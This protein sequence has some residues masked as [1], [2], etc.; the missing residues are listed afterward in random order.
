MFL[1]LSDAAGVVYAAIIGGLV[2]IAVTLITR[3]ARK[4]TKEIVHQVTTNGGSSDSLADRVLR[5]EERQGQQHVT[6]DRRITRLERYMRLVL[7]Q[8]R[9]RD[10]NADRDSERRNQDGGDGDAEG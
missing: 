6:N 5:I 1:A 2:T 4:A 10:S 7:T 8:I 9:K 3:P